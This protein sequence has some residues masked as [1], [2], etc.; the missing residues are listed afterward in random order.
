MRLGISLYPHLIKANYDLE[1]YL[2]K[3]AKA[4]IKV[5]FTTLINVKKDNQ[6]LFQRFLTLT[7]IAHKLGMEVY[8]DVDDTVYDEFKLD[9]NNREQIMYFFTTELGLKGIRFDAGVSAEGIAKLTHNHE[10]IKIILNSSNP[11][12]EIPY[13]LSLQAKKSNLVACWNFYPQRYTASSLPYFVEK[14]TILKTEGILSQAFVALQRPDAQGPWQHND[15]LPSIEMHRDLP[16]DFQVRHFVALGV[17]D[18]IV[19]TQFLND[20][21][22]TTLNN[23]NL[24]KITLNLKPSIEITS[25]E[26]TILSDQNVHF[27]RPDLAEYMIRST[28]SRLKYRDLDIPPRSFEGK[29]FAKG[30]IVILNNKAQN[31][32]GELQIITKQMASDG[33]RNWVGQLDEN[34]QNII[35]CL[36]PNREFSFNLI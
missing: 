25:A 17:D 20:E 3:C 32:R 21:E 31:Y 29:S 2:I 30:D 10:D 28:F 7:K 16:L 15:K 19:S 18:I 27:V 11:A 36:M 6:E 26:K 34:E 24:H 12:Q 22:L 13:L 9:K 23:I 14:M 33:I 35:D 1:E 5:I 4:Q 8:G